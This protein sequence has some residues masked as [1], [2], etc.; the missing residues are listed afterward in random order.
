MEELCPTVS[1]APDASGGLYLVVGVD[2][3]A[4]SHQHLDD[5]DVATAGCDQQRGG[6]VLP[7]KHTQI[8]NADSLDLMTP[9]SYSRLWSITLEIP[10]DLKD[11]ASRY[12]CR[13]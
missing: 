7:H 12:L 8:C 13:N 10:I 4:L 6:A 5:L 2:L 1:D 3:C 11:Q 9:Q